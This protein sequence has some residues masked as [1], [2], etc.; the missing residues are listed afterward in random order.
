LRKAF[1]GELLQADAKRK[2]GHEGSDADGDTESCESV[3]EKG[4][5]KIAEREIGE[6]AGFHRGAA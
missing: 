2:H 4:L 5:A 6:I 1:G 3:A